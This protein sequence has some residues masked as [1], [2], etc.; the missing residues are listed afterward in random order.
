MGS[1]GHIP[2]PC[3][4]GPSVLVPPTPQHVCSPSLGRGMSSQEARWYTGAG[5]QVTA[6]PRGGASSGWP[7][8][9]PSSCS[10]CVSGTQDGARAMMPPPHGLPRSQVDSLGCRLR[11][12]GCPKA[13]NHSGKAAVDSGEVS[14][15]RPLSVVSQ[16]T[17]HRTLPA[18]PRGA[19][20]GRLLPGP[21]GRWHC[22]Q[23]AVL[24][25]E[26]PRGGTELLPR[27]PSP[28]RGPPLQRGNQVSSLLCLHLRPGWAGSG[29][30]F[31]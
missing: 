13:A 25:S 3:V 17:S 4:P 9:E 19:G 14:G 5:R 20:W 10:G 27:L 11:V 21:H 15:P 22:P 24:T 26:V 29:R 31:S 7:S 12:A 6:S 2:L 1:R 16:A 18:A 30:C 8:I 23:T 28:D